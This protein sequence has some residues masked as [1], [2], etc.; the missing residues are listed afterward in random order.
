MTS[1]DCDCAC[2]CSRCH[3]PAPCG[4]LG[5][6]PV[7]Q[8]SG[9]GLKDSLED[10]GLEAIRLSAFLNKASHSHRKRT[11]HHGSAD[12]VA[13]GILCRCWPLP[14]NSAV[15]LALV[16]PPYLHASRLPTIPGDYPSTNHWKLVGMSV[17]W[18]TP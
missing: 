7:P 8:A 14:F 9:G 2:E 12:T 3:H 6:V 10:L 17:P 4:F 15:M 16:V 5:L 1:C 18:P 13:L 11:H